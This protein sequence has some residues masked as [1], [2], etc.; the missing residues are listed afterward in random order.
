MQSDD[1]SSR[2]HGQLAVS[3]AARGDSAQLVRDE[4]TGS[5]GTAGSSREQCSGE[6]SAH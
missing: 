6:M 1:E 5:G 2:R 4:R 3:A